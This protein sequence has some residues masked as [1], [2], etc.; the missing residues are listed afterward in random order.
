MSIVRRLS[1]HQEWAECDRC[2]ERLLCHP[3]RGEE[4]SMGFE[5]LMMCVHCQQLASAELE[6]CEWCHKQCDDCGHRK[7]CDSADVYFICLKCHLEK[8]QLEDE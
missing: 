4:D 1:Q 2:H 3:I 8:N 7:S 6:T 5:K